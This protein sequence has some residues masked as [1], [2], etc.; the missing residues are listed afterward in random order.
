[1]YKLRD[2]LFFAAIVMLGLN[3]VF[4]YY[5]STSRSSARLDPALTQ[6][7]LM[8]SEAE[9]KYLLKREDTQ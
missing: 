7:V 5:N 3:A 8:V 1:M 4:L 9:Y 6:D 2:S